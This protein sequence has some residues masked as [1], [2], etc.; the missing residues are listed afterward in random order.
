M[1]NTTVTVVLFFHQKSNI[2]YLLENFEIILNRRRVLMSRKYIEDNVIPNLK[3]DDGKIL[4]KDKCLMLEEDLYPFHN[5]EFRSLLSSGANGVVYK[6]V[7]KILQIE[8]LVKLYCITDCAFLEKALA[9]SKKNST[10]NM[11]DSIARVYD[12]GIITKPVQFVYS[13]MEFVDNSLTLSEYLNYRSILWSILNSLSPLE[14]LTQAESRYGILF[15]ESINVASYFI[16]A[17][18][19]LIKNQIR[20]GDLNPG[21]ILICNSIFNSELIQDMKE[22]Q[23][24]PND[25]LALQK[26]M[27]FDKLQYYYSNY[28]NRDIS[29]GV[30]EEDKLKVKLIDLGASQVK[31]S[32]VEKTNQRDTWFIYD[33]INQLLTPLFSDLKISNNLCSYAFFKLVDNTRGSVKKIEYYFPFEKY[34]R[35]TEGYFYSLF[36]KKFEVLDGKIQFGQN[37]SRYSLELRDELL[38]NREIFSNNQVIPY[39]LQNEQIDKELMYS[40]NDYYDG[41]IPY[42]M[43]TAELLK[44]IGMIN[45][46]YGAIYNGNIIE[47]KTDD[48]LFQDLLKIIRWGNICEEGQISKENVIISSIFD[49]RFHEAGYILLRENCNGRV[50][51]DGLLFSY[52]KLLSDFIKILSDMNS[53]KNNAKSSI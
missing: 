29:V 1:L 23:S 33:T 20:H 27:L 38:K 15:Q 6:V 4:F 14:K 13:I 53:D 3:I 41:Q 17:I 22:Y 25:D 40:E 5:L 47:K 39:S 44:I 43:M 35:E 2:N 51:Q 21:N 28:G 45:I 19:Y 8:Q 11:A 36:G 30:V 9:E 16:R 52:Y 49:Y 42:Q 48:L 18:A 50:W 24:K 37:Q 10:L 34:S 31:P 12:V 46:F 32:T 7:H 26:D